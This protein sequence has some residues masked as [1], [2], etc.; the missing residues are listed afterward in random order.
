MPLLSKLPFRGKV[1]NLLL[2]PS[3]EQGFEKSP[4]GRITLRLSGPEGDC[5][6]GHTRAPAAS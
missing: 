3:R 1:E 6:A 5:H 2:R 4:T